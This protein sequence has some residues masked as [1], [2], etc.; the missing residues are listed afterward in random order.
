MR[1]VVANIESQTFKYIYNF[2]DHDELYNISE[3]P[4]E[5]N[6]LAEHAD[7]QAIRLQL[8]QRVAQWMTDTGDFLHIPG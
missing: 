2:E 7:Y 4:L 3:D 5:K 1:A 8:R 6:S